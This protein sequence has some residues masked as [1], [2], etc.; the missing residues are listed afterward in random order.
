VSDKDNLPEV[1][2][3][4]IWNRAA[5]HGGGPFAR[6][7]DRALAALLLCHGY[8]M[9]GGVDHAREGL[10]ANE[11]QAACD[12]YRRYGLEGVADLLVAAARDERTDDN[13]YA[14]LVPSDSA[15][16]VRFEGDLVAR[17]SDYA[18]TDD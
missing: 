1:V 4:L 7:G 18:P 12:S 5:L 8:V 11:L 14:C 2:R 10:A 13:A 17:P 9:N 6:A 3:L 15:L 16:V